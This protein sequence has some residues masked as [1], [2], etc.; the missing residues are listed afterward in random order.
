MDFTG[1]PTR[2]WKCRPKNFAI[3]SAD[4]L[5]LVEVIKIKIRKSF[6]GLWMMS[7]KILKEY[8]EWVMIYQKHFQ[9]FEKN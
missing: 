2:F 8:E 4:T 1:L 3:L 7:Y 9:N 5:G 6:V